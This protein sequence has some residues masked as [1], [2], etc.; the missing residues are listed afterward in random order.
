MQNLARVDETGP[1]MAEAGNACEILHRPGC[2]LGRTVDGI[3]TRDTE[4]G[5][6]TARTRNPCEKPVKFGR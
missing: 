2:P 1:Q 5:L 4:I 3:L 6:K